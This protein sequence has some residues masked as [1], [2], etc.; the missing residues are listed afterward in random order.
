MRTGKFQRIELPVGAPRLRGGAVSRLPLASRHRCG[1][2][3]RASSLRFRYARFR[4]GRFR[5]RWFRNGR[6]K[7]RGDGGPDDGLRRFVR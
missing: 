6:D 7:L 2:D 4:N 1:A 5:H 3:R